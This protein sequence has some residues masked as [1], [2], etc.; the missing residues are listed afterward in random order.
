MKRFFLLASLISTSLFSQT[1]PNYVPANGLVGWW[2]FNGTGIPSN[3]SA[4]TFQVNGPI[5][6]SDR[7]GNSNGC[8]FFNG[9]QAQAEFLSCSQIS[10]FTNPQYSFSI[11]FNTDQFYPNQTPTSPFD[12]NNFNVQGIVSM[13][14]NS[15]SSA[16]AISAILNFD[17][18]KIVTEHPGSGVQSSSLVSINN[19]YHLIVTFDG[20]IFR[21]YVNG[22]LIGQNPSTVNYANQN[23][24]VIGGQRNGPQMIPMGGF[25]GKIDDFGWWNRALTPS[26]VTQINFGCT[27][28]I[29]SQPQN[30]TAF[31]NPGFAYFKCTSIDPN[32]TYQWQ[33]NSGLGWVDLA[34]FGIYSGTNTDSL[35]LN[36]VGMAQ[37]NTGFRCVV[38]NCQTYTSNQ[39]ILTVLN[40]VGVSENSLQRVFVSPTPTQGSVDLGVALEGTYTLIGIDG[41]AVQ[42]GVLRQVLDFSQQPAG[43]YS[44][45]LETAA[46]SRVL[47][48]VKE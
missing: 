25:N 12:F 11:W 40:G 37:N 41:R 14:S 29:I 19:W 17:N 15:W 46:G 16:P 34:D 36:G 1:V 33:M 43:V 24:L 32:S 8:Y 39:A 23:D 13:N 7:H 18:S 44:L 6:A 30:F 5:P 20:S 4:P 26:E 42:T 2:P 10:T 35:V 28:S 27:D 22:V 21:Q 38:T 3:P 48:V 9:Q 45:R 31:V 47:K